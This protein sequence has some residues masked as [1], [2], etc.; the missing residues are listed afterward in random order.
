[1][2]VVLALLWGRRLESDGITVHSTH[3]GWAATPGVTDS[4]PGFA[5]VMSPLLR[6]AEQGAGRF[7]VAVGQV[8]Q[9][10][11]CPVQ[12]RGTVNEIQDGFLAHSGCGI[13]S[14]LGRSDMM[15]E[16][17]RNCPG[18]ERTKSQSNPEGI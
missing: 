12:V 1:M 7:P 14:C 8:G 9:R 18:R 13:V 2:Q 4:L 6:D 17:K 3:P 11:E 15:N 5:K 10:V 16:A